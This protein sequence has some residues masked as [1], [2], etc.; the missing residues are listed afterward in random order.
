MLSP[1]PLYA[2]KT[3][4][5][6]TLPSAHS[7]SKMRCSTNFRAIWWKWTASYYT[8]HTLTFLLFSKLQNHRCVLKVCPWLSLSDIPIFERPFSAFI[9]YSDSQNI[10]LALNIYPHTI[11]LTT[12]K[13]PFLNTHETSIRL[14]YHA[15][16]VKFSLASKSWNN[17]QSILS[18]PSHWNVI[19]L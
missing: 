1:L 8:D 3:H 11:R 16:S 13:H 17:F 7:S 18:T 9:N 5:S 19:V 6:I 2:L 4:L 10:N 15:T 12:S 14:Y